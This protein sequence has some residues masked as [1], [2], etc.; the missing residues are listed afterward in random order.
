VHL[1][2]VPTIAARVDTSP[3]VAGP[4]QHFAPMLA[5]M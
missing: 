1:H 5:E 4:V 2:L 3:S